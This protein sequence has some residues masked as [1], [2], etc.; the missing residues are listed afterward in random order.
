MRWIQEIQTT[1]ESKEDVVA[2]AAMLLAIWGFRGGELTDAE[3]R[4]IHG[5]GIFRSSRSE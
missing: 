4:A 5:D 1:W 3:F 2:A